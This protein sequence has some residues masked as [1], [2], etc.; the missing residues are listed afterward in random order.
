MFASQD[1][2]HAIYI[3]I[4]KNKLSFPSFMNAEA[5]S[6]LKA[7]LAGDLALRLSDVAVIKAHPWFVGV[8]WI[9]LYQVQRLWC[10]L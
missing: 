4:I 1:P 2:S 3:S 10:C 9:A 5:K 6:L 8:D 7:L